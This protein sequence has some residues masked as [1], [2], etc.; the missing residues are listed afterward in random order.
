MS[1][2]SQKPRFSDARGLNMAMQSVP[3]FEFEGVTMRIFPLRA[4]RD[5]VQRFVNQW[6]NIVP[7]EV[8]YFRAYLPYVFLDLINYGRMSAVAANLGWLAQREIAFSIPLEWYKR[9]G[10]Q[11]VFHDWAY[12]SPFIYVDS[13]L[14]MTTGREVYGWPK[15]LIRIDRDESDWMKDPRAPGRLATISATVF[16]E[17]YAGKQEEPRDFLHVERT[18]APSPYQIP[19]DYARV[20]GPW[21]NVPGMLQNGSALWRDWFDLLAGVGV[22]RAHPGVGPESLREMSRVLAQSYRPYDPRPY[23]NTVNLKQFRSSDMP[24]AICYQALTNARMDITAVNGGGMLGD[25]QV[26]LGDPSGGLR[27]YIHR[28]A[29]EPVVETLGLEVEEEWNGRDT[30]VASIAPVMPYWVDLDMRYGRAFTQAFRTKTTGWAD[31]EGREIL[32]AESQGPPPYNT[33]RGAASQQ[34]G[35][36][37][38]FPNTTLRVLPLLAERGP[39]QTFCDDYLNEPLAATGM[40]FEPWGTYVYL[41][42]ASNEGAISESNNIGYWS[43]RGVTFYIPV[44]WY[45]TVDGELS[46]RTLALVPV[47]S[48]ANSTTAANTGSEVSGIPTVQVAIESPASTW[49]DDAGPSDASERRLLRMVA[50]VLPVLGEGQKTEHRDLVE[51][52]SGLVLPPSDRTA[53]RLVSEGWGQRLKDDLA[54]MRRIAA[55]EHDELDDARALALEVLANGEALNVVTMKQFR[56]GDDPDAACYQSLVQIRH[57]LRRVRD[58]R[59]IEGRLYVRIHDYASQPI[60]RTLGLV[61]KRVCSDGSSTVLEIEPVRPFWIHA[62]LREE[63]G[64]TV[65]RRS[66]SLQWESDPDTQ[67][68]RAYFQADPASPGSGPEVGRELAGLVDAWVPQRLEPQS[69]EWQSR[70]TSARIDVGG[71]RRAVE[72]IDPQMVLQSVLSREWENWGTPRW[73]QVK[74]GLA[75]DLAVIE[76]NSLLTDAVDAQIARLEL[77]YARLR[78]ETRRRDVI[79]YIER[80]RLFDKLRTAAHLLQSL[81]RGHTLADELRQLTPGVG[82]HDGQYTPD[83]CSRALSSGER[84]AVAAVFSSDLMFDVLQESLR[85]SGYDMR[86]PPSRRD[87]FCARLCDELQRGP[88]ERRDEIGRRADE[89]ANAW[90]VRARD[91]AGRHL[92]KNLQAPAI[93]EAFRDALTRIGISTP[94]SDDAA[95]FVQ[96]LWQELQNHPDR[97]GQI[98]DAGAGVAKERY[99]WVRAALL[100]ALSKAAQKPDLCI[101]TDTIQGAEQALFF[102]RSE[103]WTDEGGR[104]WYVGPEPGTHAPTELDGIALPLVNAA[105]K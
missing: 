101:S 63:L 97:L 34:I 33:S 102:P 16:P 83:A 30:T 76:R 39:L 61:P 43:A 78:V 21:M 99:G 82:L 104:G 1:P 26:L 75:R 31:A 38:D 105:Q 27:V 12:L 67:Q 36:P 55:R 18:V 57:H 60:A 46:L 77:A 23:F 44:K 80:E 19:I 24:S 81:S 17:V 90:F 79:A 103:C 42:V 72:A 10:G 45:E 91:E 71:A 41:V 13:N 86:D 70:P 7:P 8:G 11:Y 74:D 64:I 40:R 96:D 15:A 85:T 2:R 20:L 69:R 65:C 3:P 52:R 49:L 4:K 29:S 28:Y 59:E 50:E 88:A 54:R 51:V 22:L 92:L 35:G 5:I 73:W 47:F 25:P 68:K 14:S 93:F 98:A 84:T 9:V 37:F 58:L 32:G 6:L 87:E 62:S 48:Y 94:K 89:L 100:H 95:T 56:D 66:G 53:W